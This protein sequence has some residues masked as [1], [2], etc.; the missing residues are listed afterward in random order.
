MT[1]NQDYRETDPHFDGEKEGIISDS[2]GKQVAIRTEKN[3]SITNPFHINSLKKDPEM[4]EFD[5][6]LNID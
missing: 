1:D 6:T 4:E 3:K 2:I 5:E